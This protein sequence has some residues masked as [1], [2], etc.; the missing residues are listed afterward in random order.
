MLK[1]LQPKLLLVK[2]VVHYV[3][4]VGLFHEYVIRMMS[5]KVTFK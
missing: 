2:K 3:M 4:K 1:K 5:S